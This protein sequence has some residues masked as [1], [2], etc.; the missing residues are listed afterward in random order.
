MDRITPEE[1]SALMSQ[2]RGS[3]TGPEIAVRRLLHGLGLRF[4]LHR[5]DL[6]GRPDI[7][8]PGRR[9]VVFV[10]GCFWHRHPNCKRA[11][12]PAS[13]HAYWSKK[14]RRNVERDA[15]AKLALRRLKWRMLVVWECELKNPEKLRRR[16]RR[17]FQI[18]NS[19][20]TAAR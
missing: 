10:H 2:V 16:L 12:T 19:L 15:E 18:Q 6:P 11:T 9:A 17:F 20:T 4:R 8:L 3:H 14:F 1:R 7:V 13:N 5:R